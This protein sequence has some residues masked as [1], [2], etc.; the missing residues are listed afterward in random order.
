MHRILALWCHPRSMSTAVERIMRERGD[1][2][3]L[4]EPFMYDY[5]LHRRVRSMPHFE[6]EAGRPLSYAS[7][8]ADL[9]QRARHGDVFFKDMSYYVMPAMRRDAD[10]ARRITHT[11]L[12]REPL[13]AILSYHKLDPDLT[14]EEVGL[15]A[16]WRHFE[17]LRDV[18]GVRPVVLRAEALQ[19][20]PQTVVGAW[21]RAA[22][23]AFA[24]HAFSWSDEEAPRDWGQVAGWHGAVQK[25]TAIRPADDDDDLAARFEEAARDNPHLRDL[26][27]H[28]QPFYDRL[29]GE[30]ETLAV[31]G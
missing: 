10:F 20:D 26:L 7:I 24:P 17:W 8:R 30:A 21:W 3:C 29:R 25:S 31:E 9:L 4:H 2:D 15:E 16:Q 22:G 14:C 1:F 5:Y 23:I 6:P 19:A 13:R 27:A 11:F 12:I 18:L 28:H